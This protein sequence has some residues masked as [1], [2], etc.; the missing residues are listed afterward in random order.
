MY[1]GFRFKIIYLRSGSVLTTQDDQITG[2]VKV[3]GALSIIV[4]A[5]FNKQK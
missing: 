2:H 3:T 4:L 5:L 1:N